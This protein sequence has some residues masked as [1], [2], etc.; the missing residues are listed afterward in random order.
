MTKGYIDLTLRLSILDFYSHL[1]KRLFLTAALFLKALTATILLRTCIFL[2]S[3]IFIALIF[4]FHI[5]NFKVIPCFNLQDILSWRKTILSFLNYC[6][7]EKALIYDI[8][9]LNA[10]L[11]V[12]LS[13]C[14]KWMI[15]WVFASPSFII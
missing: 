9:C 14:Y 13:I 2:T 10:R 4:Y 12:H 6:Y 7:L 5:L 1:Q 15:E 11:S 3:F 8:V